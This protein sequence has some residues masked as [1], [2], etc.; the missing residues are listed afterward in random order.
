MDHTESIF[1]YKPEVSCRVKSG[2]RFFDLNGRSFL[3]VVRVVKSAHALQP[4]GQPL[5]SC[6]ECE[7]PQVSLSNGLLLAYFRTETFGALRRQHA[8]DFEIACLTTGTEMA[9]HEGHKP[10]PG[11]WNPLY[12]AHGNCDEVLQRRL[13]AHAGRCGRF[14]TMPYLVCPDGVWETRTSPARPVHF[15]PQAYREYR[16]FPAGFVL[17]QE[18]GLEVYWRD[19]QDVLLHEDLAAT[20]FQVTDY[21]GNGYNDLVA[22]GNVYLTQRNETAKRVSITEFQA[23]SAAANLAAEQSRERAQLL[24]LPLDKL[25]NLLFTTHRNDAELLQ[26]AAENSWRWWQNAIA[27]NRSLAEQVEFYWHAKLWNE[28]TG[29]HEVDDRAIQSLLAA[30][31]LSNL[32]DRR[33]AL[34][35]AKQSGNNDALYRGCNELRQEN[36]K[37]LRTFDEAVSATQTAAQTLGTGW[38]E[39]RSLPFPAADILSA[40][41]TAHRNAKELNEFLDGVCL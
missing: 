30:T 41:E 10:M 31:R 2:K 3:E 12:D 6:V 40:R 13:N 39:Y 16:P 1:A 15:L 33:E 25:E 27:E 11:Y 28:I 32:A 20:S 21:D 38:E 8:E 23:N 17:V 14:G 19:K 29:R 34:L 18:G 35:Q 24:R 36:A 37:L 9:G 5:Q 26:T 7:L 22:G 4:Q